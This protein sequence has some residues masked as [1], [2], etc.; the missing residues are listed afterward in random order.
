MAKGEDE[1]NMGYQ[2]FLKMVY[3]IQN[4]VA[5]YCELMYV[6]NYEFSRR[7]YL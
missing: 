2:F 6:K 7:T 1:E 3:M 4:M 5:T